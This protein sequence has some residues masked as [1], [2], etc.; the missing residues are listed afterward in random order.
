MPD[1]AF[2]GP[3]GSGVTKDGSVAGE[4]AGEGCVRDVVFGVA[5]GVGVAGMRTAAEAPGVGLSGAGL[6]MS[7]PPA[8]MKQQMRSA[9]A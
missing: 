5:E 9:T 6:M 7:Q 2:P 8:V 4:T 3:T 1:Q